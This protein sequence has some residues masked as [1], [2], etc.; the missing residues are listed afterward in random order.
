MFWL[1]CNDRLFL[2]RSKATRSP[3]LWPFFISLSFYYLKG[4]D[5]QYA[6]RYIVKWFNDAKGFGYACLKSSK[7][8]M[9]NNLVEKFYIY[10]FCYKRNLI[11]IKKKSF[12]KPTVK[13]GFQGLIQKMKTFVE[14]IAELTENESTTE[15]ST[16]ASIF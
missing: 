1:Y 13:K 10:N 16:K 4:G 6:K 7:N 5:L 3:I 8:L 11:M 9:V 15:K 14:R 2:L 12:R